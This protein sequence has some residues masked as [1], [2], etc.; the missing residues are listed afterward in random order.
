MPEK[1]AA[2][3][4]PILQA[5]LS[6]P[7]P[8]IP[9]LVLFHFGNALLLLLT[10]IS[11]LSW[12][13]G[14]NGKKP[15]VPLGLNKSSAALDGFYNTSPPLSSWQPWKKRAHKR[16]LKTISGYVRK[17]N[18]NDECKC[19]LL[20]PE[21]LKEARIP[22]QNKACLLNLMI[23]VYFFKYWDKLIPM[24]PWITVK[25]LGVFLSV[26]FNLT[27]SASGCLSVKIVWCK[28]KQ[29]KPQNVLK[30]TKRN[31]DNYFCRAKCLI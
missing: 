2:F 9:L 5:F 4:A 18:G 29:Q 26:C 27:L 17:P 23:N 12:L 10:H 22:C 20:L 6:F 21:A 1:R 19:L 16:K 28:K 11:P 14:R 3:A 7:S 15:K 31:E 30:V 25:T 24:H 8:N 13:S